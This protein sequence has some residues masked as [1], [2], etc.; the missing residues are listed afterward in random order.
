VIGALV[1]AQLTVFAASSLR[2]AF[3]EIAAAF[4]KQEPG[5][6]VVLQFAG[7][8]QLRVQIDNGASADVFA[9]A[10][11]RHMAGLRDLVDP[12]A[13]FA[14]NELVLV[15]PA[16]NP[17]KLR[18]FD[19]LP[20]ARRV[21]LGDREVPVGAYAL[22]A[23]RS[24]GAAF[25]RAVEERVVSR[26]LNVRQV[27]SKVALGEADAGIVYRTDAL[28]AGGK[29]RIV[30]IPSAPVARYPIGIVKGRAAPDLARS[31]V[32][33]VQSSGGQEVLRRK[34]FLAP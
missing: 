11:E 31:F 17:A 8:Q 33:L 26:E 12:P 32:S 23:L 25:Q 21:V 24:K 22:E 30:A 7:S 16:S 6:K 28:T 34:G 1:A 5:A 2:E 4:E 15:V 10:D 18:S 14:R 20:R 9:S 29:V 27:L 13:V 3:T 19:D